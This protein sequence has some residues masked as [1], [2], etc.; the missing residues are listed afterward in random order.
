MYSMVQIVRHLAVSCKRHALSRYGITCAKPQ[1]AYHRYI[2]AC[3]CLKHYDLLFKYMNPLPYQIMIFVSL[4]H[5]HNPMT[6]VA[7]TNFLS[8]THTSSSASP[9]LNILSIAHIHFLLLQVVLPQSPQLLSDTHRSIN[10]SSD[11]CLQ[12]THA[13]SISSFM[14][15]CLVSLIRSHSRVNSCPSFHRSHN[16]TLLPLSSQQ[17]GLSHHLLA[18]FSLSIRLAGP[19]LPLTNGHTPTDLPLFIQLA[20]SL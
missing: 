12:H 16:L 8:C 14:C 2:H 10:L 13:P 6:F 15:P 4:L 7:S 11:V 20:R 5:P 18:P 1:H 9:A 3:I 19:Y 17:L